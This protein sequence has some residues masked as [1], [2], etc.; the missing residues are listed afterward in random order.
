MLMKRGQMPHGYTILEVMIFLVITGALLV[1]ALAM[2]NGQQNRTRYTQGLREMDAQ[3]RAVSNEVQSGYYPSSNTV[4]CTLVGNVPTLASG[5]TRQGAN[6]DCTFLGKTMQFGLATGS[7]NTGSPSDCTQYA[8]NTVYGRRAESNNQLVQTLEDPDGAGSKRGAQP[9]LANGTNGTP[10]LSDRRT[11]PG[12]LRIYKMYA[13]RGGSVTTIGAV[14]FMY[15][16]TQYAAGSSDPVSGSRSVDLLAVPSSAL[17][18]D[19]LA[20]AGAIQGNNLHETDRN[21]DNVVLCFED[22]GLGGGRR[23]AIAIGG[24][25]RELTTQVYNNIVGANIPGAAC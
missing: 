22:Q 14:G 2:F 3:I 16:L 24:Q 13:V 12:G 9:Q 6:Q 11:I 10:D 4:Q 20:A 23:S 25:G 18:Q 15:P 17:G 5:T 8:V 1:S 7:C 19:D 21:P